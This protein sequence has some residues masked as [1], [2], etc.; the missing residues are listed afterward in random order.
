MGGEWPV[1][2]NRRPTVGWVYLEHVTFAGVK[3]FRVWHTAWFR[4]V[5]G[6]DVVRVQAWGEMLAWA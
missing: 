4:S 6:M 3:V 5:C 2:G 1:L